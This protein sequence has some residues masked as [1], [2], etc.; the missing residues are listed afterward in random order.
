MHKR[1]KD[2]TLSSG[3]HRLFKLRLLVIVIPL[4]SSAIT[5]LL[6]PIEFPSVHTD[7]GNYMNR[8][9]HLLQGIGPHEGENIYTRIFD[10]P[11]FGQI[12]V[13]AGLGVIN[14][15]DSLS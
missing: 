5:H 12:F 13:A 7:E 9:M 14:Y 6:N 15:P 2:T 11:Y 3:P 4:A 10:H 1:S 8:A